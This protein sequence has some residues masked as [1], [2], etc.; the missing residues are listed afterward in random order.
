MD[1]CSHFE[2]QWWNPPYCNILYSPILCMM[3]NAFMRSTKALRRGIPCFVCFKLSKCEDHVTS[4]LPSPKAAGRTCYVS[5]CKCFR[6]IWGKALP[7]ILRQ[8]TPLCRSSLLPLVLYS[9]TVM[10]SCMSWGVMA[11]W[12][13]WVKSLCRCGRRVS[14]F[15]LSTCTGMLS[16]PISWKI[17]DG[18]REL[19]F[20]GLNILELWNT[21]IRFLFSTVCTWDVMI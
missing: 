10:S 12:Q 13:H 19:L 3:S 8:E 17:L 16:L 6:I 4:W 14:N 21:H 7:V 9:V 18:I 5:F 2:K 11:F 1:R 15:S 20:G